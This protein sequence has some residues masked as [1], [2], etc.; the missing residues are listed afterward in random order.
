MR[1][2]TRLAVISTILALLAPS[3]TCATMPMTPQQ[4]WGCC[5]SMNF[6]CHE[7]HNRDH[8]DNCCQHKAT[9]PALRNFLPA[10]R[11]AVSHP[12]GSCV[13]ILP[14]LQVRCVLASSHVFPLATAHAP[15]GS[16][17]LFVLHS[18]FLI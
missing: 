5:R 14:L 3:F 2:I 16:T 9:G 12:S 15:P 7:Q 1:L 4:T 18:A 13:A 10:P 11:I 6:Q 17:P 8:R